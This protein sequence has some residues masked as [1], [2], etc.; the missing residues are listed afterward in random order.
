MKII[1]LYQAPHHAKQVTEWLWRE[2]GSLESR[3]FFASV[4]ASSQKEGALP[5][6]FI[7]VDQQDCLL[8]TVGLWR[9]D[10]ISRQDLW[11]W[12]AALYIDESQRGKGLGSQLQAHVIH[13]AQTRGFD[14]LYLYS[15]CQ[16][17]YERFGWQY[18]G[19]GIDYPA[20]SVHLYR[21]DLSL[22]LIPRLR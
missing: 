5:L 8:G 19:E 7:A 13:Y 12:L 16:D 17:Y 14:T 9:C 18:M 1:P 11:P 4:V 20:T 15:A 3:D 6:T 2:F 22:P 10:L 21:H